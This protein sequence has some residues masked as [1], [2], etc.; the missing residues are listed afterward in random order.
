MYK[1]TGKSFVLGLTF[2]MLLTLVGFTSVASASTSLAGADRYATAIKI[3]QAGWTMSDN[4]IIARGDDLAD[5]LAAAPLAYAKG[6]APILLT[7]TNKL[8]TGV[9]D[10]LKALGVKNVYIVGGTG[11]VSTAV[12][13]ALKDFNVI[14]LSGTDR[15]DTSYKVALEAF[16]TAPTG[17]VIANGYAYADA[18]SISSIAAAKGMPIL[19]VDS[20]QLSASQASYIAGKTV[21]AVGGTGVLSQAVIDMAKAKRL[22]GLDRYETNSAILNEFPQYYSKVYLAKGTDDNLVDALAGSALA[23]LG[24][25]PI[26]LVDGNSVINA[27]S[28][29]II[30]ANAS[31]N[32][33]EVLL[34]GTVAKSAADVVETLKPKEL[35]IN[36]KGY[37]YNTELLVDLKIRSAPNLNGTI[38]G[39]L[40]NYNKVEILDTIVDSSNNVWGKIAYNNSFAY[41]YKAY[42]QPYTSPTEDVVSIAVNITKQFEASTSNQ[43]AGNF[44]GQGLSLGNLQWCIGQGTLQPILNRMDRE[45]NA[46][47]R[48]IFGANYD[49]IHNMTL[50]TLENQLK[51][52]MNIND[53]T[54]KIMEPWY[55]QFVSLCTNQGFI[56]IETEAQVYT[57]KQ[58]MIICDKYNLKTVRGF[59]LAFDIV[60]Q[61]GSINSGAIRIIDTALVQNP[62]MI[63]KN[64][65]GVIANAVADSSSSNSADIRSRKIAIVNGQGTVHGSMLYLDKNFG[66]SDN[67][68]R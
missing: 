25:N 47:M 54:N 60:T 26:V 28:S 6:R 43:V 58:A 7:E 40:Y 32:S 24:N 66:L 27:K 13:N 55:S 23:A 44:D 4:A 18:L 1:K 67:C 14:R 3:V 10:E 59:A 29:N 36:K 62:S 52:A 39:Y 45:Y 30:K 51:W 2:A 57:V 34:G 53:G 56:K 63:E 16:K 11:A 42:I 8:P 68:W 21:Y 50:D 31:V 9:L 20:K 33:T 19:L 15:A 41:V 38:L 46:Q 49:S 37:V 65:L 35:P 5:A 64:L 61:N 17:V 22:S 48:S 12:E